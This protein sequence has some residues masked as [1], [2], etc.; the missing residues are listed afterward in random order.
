MSDLSDY[1]VN[2]VDESSD[3]IDEELNIKTE[4]PDDDEEN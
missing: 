2:E 3:S 4:I 1:D